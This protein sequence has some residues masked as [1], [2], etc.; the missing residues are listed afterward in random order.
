MM[1][2]FI[3]IIVVLALA[4][5]VYISCKDDITEKQFGRLMTL[6]VFSLL[7]LLLSEIIVIINMH[8]I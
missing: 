7:F 3:V 8:T 4:L 6:S 5:Q 2:I 1:F